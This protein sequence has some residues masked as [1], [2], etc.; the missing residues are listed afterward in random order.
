MEYGNE[1]AVVRCDHWEE[2]VIKQ[3]VTRL[4]T[5]PILF[6]VYIKKAID[7]VKEKLGDT[8]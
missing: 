5:L 4:L 7:E 2:T 1:L 3:S 6:N 8:G